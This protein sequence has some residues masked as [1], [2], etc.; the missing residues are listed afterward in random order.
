MASKKP[1]KEKKEEKPMGRPTDYT[2][3]M[4]SRICELVATHDMGLT[5]LYQTY[6]DIPEKTTINR[7]R[8]RHPEFRIQYAQAKAQQLEFLTEDILEIADDA[9]NDWMEWHGKENDCLG[10]KFNGEHVQRS[11][12]RIDTRKWL[13]S[14]LAPK[15]YGDKLNQ[16]TNT[17]S[18]T[19][20]KIR[21]LVD[22]LNKE[23]L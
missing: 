19:L 16:E 3:E 7:W 8:V 22:D 5:R 11:R 13:A 21:E 17:P 18:E 4:A 1:E 10:W 12:V 20:A 9:T 6:P 23:D 2:K 15:I 14:K